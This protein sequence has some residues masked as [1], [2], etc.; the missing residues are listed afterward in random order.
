METSLKERIE[1]VLVE[2]HNQQ[3]VKNCIDILNILE[4]SYK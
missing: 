2:E 3:I 1:E 4:M